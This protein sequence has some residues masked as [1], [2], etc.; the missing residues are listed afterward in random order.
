MARFRSVVLFG[1]TLVPYL[2]TAEPGRR[3]R[4]WESEPCKD[5]RVEPERA[6]DRLA[7]NCMCSSVGGGPLY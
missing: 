3:G 6:P 4:V 5:F 7:P 2:V 1:H